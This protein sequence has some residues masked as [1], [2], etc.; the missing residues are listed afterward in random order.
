MVSFIPLAI[1][2]IRT[3]SKVSITAYDNAIRGL[4][5]QLSHFPHAFIIKTTA[6]SF[7]PNRRL[8][9]RSLIWKMSMLF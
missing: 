6:N 2:R 8:L 3:I 9:A 4:Q 7:A 1:M 5:L